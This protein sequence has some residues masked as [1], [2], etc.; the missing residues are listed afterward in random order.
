MSRIILLG[1]GFDLAHNYVTLYKDF[2]DFIRDEMVHIERMDDQHISWITN[3]EGKSKK[4]DKDNFL[5][6]LEYINKTNYDQRQ[7][8]ITLLQ[9]LNESGKVDKWLSVAAHRTIPTPNDKTPPPPPEIKLIPTSSFDQ[10]APKSIYY[11]SLF[12][13]MTQYKDWADL[14]LHYF[15]TIFKHKQNANEIK[16]INEEFEHLKGLLEEYLT[17]NIENKIKQNK[18]AVLLDE[19]KE[20]FRPEKGSITFDTTYFVSFNYTSILLQ[21]YYSTLK[22]EYPSKEPTKPVFNE[23]IFIHGQ[24]GNKNNPIIFGYGDD[25]SSKYRRIER[26]T[27]TNILKNFKTFHYLAANNYHKLLGIIEKENNIYVQ[28]VGHSFGLCDKTLLRHIFHH[29]N[30]KHIEAI[31]HKDEYFKNLYS[32]SKIFDDN[33]KMREKVVSLVD[34]QSI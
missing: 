24:L 23:P 34:T 16:T 10:N 20:I 15:D 19:M 8:E 29:N 17:E 27:N 9:K 13:K 14:E 6:Y 1:N 3:K 18:E 33:S 30:V 12:E 25:N 2:L 11:K 32:L 28:V 26:Q 4:A 21:C 31:Y 7:E 22:K 5:A